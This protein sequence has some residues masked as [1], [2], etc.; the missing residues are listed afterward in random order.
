MDNS[1]AV[2]L[3]QKLK[4]ILVP[5]CKNVGEQ[6]TYTAYKDQLIDEIIAKIRRSSAPIDQKIRPELIKVDQQKIA[7]DVINRTFDIHMKILRA[8]LRRSEIE[9]EKW[10]KVALGRIPSQEAYDLFLN[11]SGT[12]PEK[13]NEDSCTQTETTSV[14]SSSSSS[15]SLEVQVNLIAATS[16]WFEGALRSYMLYTRKAAECFWSFHN[17]I[18]IIPKSVSPNAAVVHAKKSKSV[19]PRAK[20]SLPPVKPAREAAPNSV[21]RR[22]HPIAQEVVSNTFGAQ[23]EKPS[24]LY[25]IKSMVLRERKEGEN[26]V[27][28]VL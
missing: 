5:S 19:S 3:L 11:V 18:M 26:A 21:T 8:K 14:Q 28:G 10:K 16:L 15:S 7:Q 6:L 25:V 23:S 24:R 27:H 9:C 4:N 13:E 22:E 20:P 12:I 1:D 17:D 2:A